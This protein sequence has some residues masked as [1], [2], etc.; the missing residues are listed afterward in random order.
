MKVGTNLVGHL[1]VSTWLSQPLHD[2][3]HETGPPA[4]TPLPWHTDYSYLP[5]AAQESF[6][7]A[8]ALP[9]DG[10]GAS[11]FADTYGATSH[12]ARR[13]GSASSR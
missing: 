13:R 2:E 3:G 4:E 10:G 7:N 6:L 8:V 1:T 5:N 12:S 9:D 11:C